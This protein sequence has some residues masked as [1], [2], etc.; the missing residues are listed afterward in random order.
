[1]NRVLFSGHA[2]QQMHTRGIT[3]STVLQ[4]LRNP[5]EFR[6]RSSVGY[7]LADF[8]PVEEVKWMWFMR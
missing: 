4:V 3:G 8:E 2:L 6:M 1:M 5:H 7:G